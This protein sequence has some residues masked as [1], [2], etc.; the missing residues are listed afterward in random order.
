M[1]AGRVRMRRIAQPQFQGK[2]AALCRGRRGQAG[3]LQHLRPAQARLPR[4]EAIE[5]GALQMPAM[6]QR[7]HQR[8]V[9]AALV[10]A[11]P[12]TAAMARRVRLGEELLRDAQRLEQAVGFGRNALADAK[13]RVVARLDDEHVVHAMPGQRQRAGAA[14][15]A[16]ADDGDPVALPRW[17]WCWRW[18]AW[19]VCK[20]RHQRFGFGCGFGRYTLSMAVL[21]QYSTRLLSSLSNR[22]STSR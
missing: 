9:V 6:A 18:C 19:T 4:Q 14:G 7:M 11:P 21:R 8:V 2:A 5:P 10:A 15:R 13:R 16:A 12:G 20:R 22:L 3:A 17:R 1:N